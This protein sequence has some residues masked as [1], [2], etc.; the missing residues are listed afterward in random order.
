MV[1][2]FVGILIKSNSAYV[3]IIL[4]IY[5]SSNLEIG[6]GQYPKFEGYMCLQSINAQLTNRV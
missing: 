1:V 3:R 4:A 5:Y 6:W 2:G